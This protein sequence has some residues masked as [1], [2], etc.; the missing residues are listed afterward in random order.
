MDNPNQCYTPKQIAS[1]LMLSKS[2]TYAMI[3]SGE[4]PSIK[5][6]WSHRVPAAFL[7]EYVKQLCALADSL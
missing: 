3:A 6:G 7:D 2:K 5:I 4:I 1:V